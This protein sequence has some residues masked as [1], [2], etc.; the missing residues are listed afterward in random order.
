MLGRPGVGAPGEPGGG[1]WRVAA[2]RARA[3]VTS[4][5]PMR[6]SKRALSRSADSAGV[7]LPRGF[8]GEDGEHV[9]AGAGAHEVDLGLLA[10]LGGAA[11]LEDGGHVDGLDDLLEGHVGRAVHAGVGGADGGVEALGGLR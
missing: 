6:T 8:F 2:E 9:D 11:E 1:G 5:K 4:R 3:W 10:G 7:R